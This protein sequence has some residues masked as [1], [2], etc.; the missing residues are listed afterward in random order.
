M[1]INS[2]KSSSGTILLDRSQ[3]DE[4]WQDREGR[5]RFGGGHGTSGHHAEHPVAPTHRRCGTAGNL[6]KPWD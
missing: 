6:G 1:P 3:A 4:R 5:R 2:T